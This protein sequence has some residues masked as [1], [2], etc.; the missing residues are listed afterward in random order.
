MRDGYKIALAALFFAGSVL[1]IP[2]V[3]QAQFN[4]GMGP[5][6]TQSP[7]QGGGGLVGVSALTGC[8]TGGT[9]AVFG[10]QN[11]LLVTAG[12]TASTTCTITWPSTRAQ[13]P[14]CSVTPHTAAAV[15]GF[16]TVENTTTLT[17]TYT[18]VASSVWD[19]IC[20]GP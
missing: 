14:N 3:G 2:L 7:L 8:A 13:T 16:I 5:S 18:S 10:N 20:I 6:Q 15:G 4:Q 9:P 19:V 11:A 12:T 17:W 1:L